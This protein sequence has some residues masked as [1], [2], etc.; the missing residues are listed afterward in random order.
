MQNVW[1]FTNPPT[2]SGSIWATH[3][4]RKGVRLLLESQR[5]IKSTKF[6]V[7]GQVCISHQRRMT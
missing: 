2:H 7:L 1:H 4:K 5:V 3:C 6:V